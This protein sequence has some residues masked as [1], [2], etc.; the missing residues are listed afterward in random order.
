MSDAALADPCASIEAAWEAYE[1]ATYQGTL[2]AKKRMLDR[3][4]AEQNHR[5]CHCGKRTN[6]AARREDRPTIEHVIPRA[7]GGTDDYGNLAMACF[8]C[9]N[10]RGTDIFWHPWLRSSSPVIREALSRAFVA[11][12]DNTGPVEVGIAA[13]IAGFLRH[14]GIDGLLGGARTVAAAVEREIRA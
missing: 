7:F 1:A 10:A 5:C 4:S 8:A 2:A 12:L 14:R 13:A 9:N 3:L 11:W 6:E